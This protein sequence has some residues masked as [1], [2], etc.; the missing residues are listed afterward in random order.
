MNYK[1]QQLNEAISLVNVGKAAKTA[2]IITLAIAA[3]HMILKAIIGTKPKGSYVD[4]DMTELLRKITNDNRVTAYVA[5]VKEKTAFADT[6]MNVYYSPGLVNHFK[7]TERE[8]TAIL[9]HEYSHAKR[10]DGY[11][12]MATF[13][14]SMFVVTGLVKAF[15]GQSNFFIQLFAALLGTATVKKLLDLTQGRHHE[16]VADQTMVKYGYA[17]EAKSAFE[18]FYKD[19]KSRLCSQ[20]RVPENSK[21]CREIVKDLYRFDEHPDY[22][23]RLAKIANSPLLKQMG[24]V[25]QLRMKLLSI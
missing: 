15:L 6:S 24:K 17:K 23:K 14:P 21:E 9:L 5:P 19:A 25:A 8:L 10:R 18:K 13:Y 22:E 3:I 16:Y 1:Y 7:L 20:H 4:N 11:R 2:G 12:T